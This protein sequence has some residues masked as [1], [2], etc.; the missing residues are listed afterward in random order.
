VTE[1]VAPE[2]FAMAVSRAG[3]R[4]GLIV[5]AGITSPLNPAKPPKT[6]EISSSPAK[7]AGS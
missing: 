5:L 2:E 4:D 7:V 1:R 3:F 6:T